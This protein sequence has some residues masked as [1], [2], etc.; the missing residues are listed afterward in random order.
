MKNEDY[1]VIFSLWDYKKHSNVEE[2]KELLKDYHETRNLQGAVLIGEIPYAKGQING[3]SGPIETYLMDLYSA[4]FIKNN[5]GIIT[6]FQGHIYMDIWVS[7]IYDLYNQFMYQPLFPNESEADLI[8]RYFEKNHLYRTCQSPVPDLKLRFSGKSETLDWV[9]SFLQEVRQYA[10]SNEHGY[11][12]ISTSGSA[13][14]YL[15]FIGTNI[16]QYLV[17]RSH[18]AQTRHDFENNEYLAS[19]DIA[20]ANIKQPFVLLEACSASDFSCPGF[21]GNTYL[22]GQNSEALVIAGLTIP[23][24]M[25]LADPSIRSTGEAFGVNFLNHIQN[26]D[27]FK[28]GIHLLGQIC[29]VPAIAGTILFFNPEHYSTGAAAYQIMKQQGIV[30]LFDLV[31]NYFGLLDSNQVG[32]TLLG[33]PTLKP[34]VDMAWCP[35]YQ[36]SK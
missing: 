10:S 13:D 11:D 2:L 34:Y 24:S 9:L 27:I 35:E 23:G 8:N 18:S 33:D 21:L 30:A 12:Y 17:L 3:D 28:K 16:A 31:N 25:Y 15:N 14:E 22:F 20:N 6:N 5:E 26:H 4:N 29:V 19:S 36:E 1:E 32:Y 7:R